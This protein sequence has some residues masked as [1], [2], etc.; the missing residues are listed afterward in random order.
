MTRTMGLRLVRLAASQGGQTR[1]FRSLM[2][3]Y[4]AWQA[5]RSTRTA[6]YRLDDWTLRDIG[7]R[8]AQIAS[9]SHE[10][11]RLRRRGA[12]DLATVHPRVPRHG[13]RP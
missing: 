5:G 3:R 8:R 1:F 10:I 9:L 11:E 4:R 12:A 6:R 13:G 7:V 2:L